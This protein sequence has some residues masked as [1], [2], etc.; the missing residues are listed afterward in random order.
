MAGG[1]YFLGHYKTFAMTAFPLSE[2]RLMQSIGELADPDV[3]YWIGRYGSVF[4]LG[5]IGISTAAIHQWKHKAITFVVA[6]LLLSITVF[7]RHPITHWIGTYWANIFFLASLPLTAIGLSI[8]AT[9]KQG[10]KNEMMFINTIVWFI[11]WGSFAHTG[12]RYDFFISV[13]IAIGTAFV[14]R[15]LSAVV[16]EN[17]ALGTQKKWTLPPKIMETGVTTAML[18]LIL[19]WNPTGGHATRALHVAKVQ[20][21][22]PENP[23][24]MHAYKWIKTNLQPDKTVIAAQWDYGTQLNVHSNVKTITDPDHYLPHWVH[25]YYRHVYCAQS[26]TEALYFLKTHNATH[27]MLTS[28]DFISRAGK[29]SFVGSDASFDRH[30]D[31]YPLLYLP[32]APGTQYALAPE[33]QLIDT[34]TPT[35]DLTFIEIKGTAT[36]KLTAIA[37]FKNDETE[38]LPYVAFHGSKRI[39]SEQT[40]KTQKGGLLLTFDTKGILRNAFYIS[41]IGWK[42]IAFKLF[43]RGEHSEVFENIYTDNSKGK[44]RPPDVQIWKINYPEHIKPH[45]KYLATH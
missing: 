28:A 22:Y 26:E 27:L 1:L 16:S 38:Q 36:E 13:P 32:T 11:L 6:F 25:L 18:I 31:L 42:S 17:K 24:I 14:I 10:D 37:H 12:K 39:L 29:N 15:Y 40:D 34:W 30:F 44:D 45:P 43:I 41:E 8:A 5:S 23:N 3:R 2:N 7:F 33:R 4:V 9:R 35:T 21:I 19:F 20:N